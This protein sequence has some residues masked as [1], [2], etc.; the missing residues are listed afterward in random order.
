MFTINLKI[1]ASILT[2]MALGVGIGQ[3]AE[4]RWGLKMEAPGFLVG[5]IAGALFGLALGFLLVH[6]K[7]RWI[8][9]ATLGAF[10]LLVFVQGGLLT[11]I[12]TVAAIAITFIVSAGVLR[13][14]Y[15]GSDLDAVRHHFHIWTGIRGGFLVVDKGKIVIPSTDPPHLGPKLVIVRPGNAVVMTNGGSISRI[16]GPSTFVSA[17]F[18]YVS[19]VYDL[20]RKRKSITVKDVVSQ[21]M[22]PVSASISYVCGIDVAEETIRGHNSTVQHA[23]GSRGLTTDDIDTIERIHTLY[24][25]WEADVYRAVE[26]ALR[27]LIGQSEPTELVNHSSYPRFGRHVQQLAFSSAKTVGGRIELVTV[28]S[29]ELNTELRDAHIE[30]QKILTLE[31]AKGGGFRMAITE[32]AAGYRTA[33]ALRR[34]LRVEDIHRM[35][36]H[37]MMEHMAED[38]ATKVILPAAKYALD[39]IQGVASNADDLIDGGQPRLPPPTARGPGAR[40]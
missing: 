26:G 33:L 34:D 24:P 36:A 3:W 9:V 4:T 21:D 22:D 40:A 16:C 20:S 35:A 5:A 11:M 14:M 27:T 29:I 7:R 15:G 23:G 39:D 10:L 19:K 6:Q 17:N 18:E 38:Q 2:V 8:A 13:E 32:I 31:H 37:L 25:E 28:S 30:G 12:Y 1:F